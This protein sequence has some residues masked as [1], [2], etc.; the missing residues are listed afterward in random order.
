MK[1]SSGA[2][3]PI[4]GPRQMGTVV[5]WKGAFGWVEPSK[6]IKHPNAHKHGGKVYLAAED[7]SEELDG[8]GCS[9][10]FTLYSDG[11]GLGAADCR[12]AK[13]PAKPAFQGNN[14]K[15]ATSGAVANF[16]AANSP[17]GKAAGKG[18]GKQQAGAA[19]QTALAVQ[20]AAFQKKPQQ[21][22]GK[23]G[24][25]SAMPKA[26]GKGGFQAAASQMQQNAGNWRNNAQ[27]GFQGKAAGKAAGKNTASQKRDI[28]HD[29]PL[30]GT[31][32]QWR[33]KFGWL[34]PHDT[35]D[36]PL[37]DKHQGDLYLT[38]QDVEEEIEGEGSVVSFILYGDSKGLGAMN[39][40][41]A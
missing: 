18:K 40:K 15:P 38:Q 7:V 32:V 16:R 39:V 6:P 4:N 21:A 25:Q 10:N 17:G 34:K 12:M 37:A 36:H 35:I 41:P 31:I 26:G 19:L 1:K 24:F 30:L 22:P 8:I 14:G 20:Q 2:R 33:G 3:T 29:Q 27:G 28:L 9:V 23:G 13:G 5:D 11:T